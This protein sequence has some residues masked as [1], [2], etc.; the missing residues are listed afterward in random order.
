[1]RKSRTGLETAPRALP[2]YTK[3]EEE[4]RESQIRYGEQQKLDRIRGGL[5]D[6]IPARIAVERQGTIIKILRALPPALRKRPSGD[7]TLAAIIAGLEERGI[8]ASEDTVKYDL[9]ILGA[10]RLRDAI[11]SWDQK[12][13]YLWMAPDNPRGRRKRRQQIAE[14]RLSGKPDFSNSKLSVKTLQEMKAGR[15]SLARNQKQQES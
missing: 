11:A 6:R 7:K 2:I 8:Y 15:D 12:S 14:L 1:M 9:K 4:I 13:W 5:T 10:A 3:E